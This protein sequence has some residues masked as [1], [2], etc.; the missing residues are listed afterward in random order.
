MTNNPKPCPNMNIPSG[1]FTSVDATGVRKADGKPYKNNGSVKGDGGCFEL[2]IL[3]KQI[4]VRGE[5]KCKGWIN[6]GYGVLL[7]EK[8]DEND[9]NEA[10]KDYSNYE[11]EAADSN[12]IIG[13]NSLLKFY[14]SDSPLSQSSEKDYFHKVIVRVVD[15]DKFE[16]LQVLKGN[17]TSFGSWERI[18][19]DYNY[20][21]EDENEEPAK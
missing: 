3:K 17:G 6:S 21:E 5:N 12:N 7:K 20:L 9:K 15:K 8:F 19:K 14:W 18:R 2:T 16:L 4:F 1:I 10:E 13:K 11:E